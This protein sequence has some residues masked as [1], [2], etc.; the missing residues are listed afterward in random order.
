MWKRQHQGHLQ[1]SQN[2]QDTNHP[3]VINVYLWSNRKAHL[4]WQREAYGPWNILLFSQS[5]GFTQW[6]KSQSLHLHE[7]EKGC[8]LLASNSWRD[9]FPVLLLFYN[10]LAR[11][12]SGLGFSLKH[13]QWTRWTQLNVMFI[14]L[15]CSFD[16]E[17][18]FLLNSFFFQ[19]EILKCGWTIPLNSHGVASINIVENRR[20]LGPY[21]RALFSFILF[22]KDVISALIHC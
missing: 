5:C 7:R 18:G 2:K 20:L 14:F 11:V 1:V 15:T 17:L 21:C 6:Q 8:D 10:V 16:N 4:G 22:M 9:A 19:T 3:S 12:T 13:L